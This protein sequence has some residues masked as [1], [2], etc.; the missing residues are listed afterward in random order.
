MKRPPGIEFLVPE[1]MW[2]DGLCPHSQMYFNVPAPA[3]CA[4]MVDA[5]DAVDAVDVVGC[6]WVDGL[7]A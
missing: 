6:K 2:L 1:G 7:T 4:A 5:V 3:L